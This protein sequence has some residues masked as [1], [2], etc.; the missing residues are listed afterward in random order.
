MRS[1]PES[2]AQITIYDTSNYNAYIR[3]PYLAKAAEG[4]LNHRHDA[5][6]ANLWTA[7]PPGDPQL[8]TPN[9]E[10]ENNQGQTLKI[11][12]PLERPVR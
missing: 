11:P 12:R 3:Q 2:A 1:F 10:L 9:P 7:P 5:I 8:H 6:C 4:Q